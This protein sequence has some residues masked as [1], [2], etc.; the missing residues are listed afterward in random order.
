MPHLR[1]STRFSMLLK[2][3]EPPSAKLYS[4]TFRSTSTVRAFFPGPGYRS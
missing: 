4:E 3:I 2:T 1:T